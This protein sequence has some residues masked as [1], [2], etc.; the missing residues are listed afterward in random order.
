MYEGLLT[1]I[2]SPSF[3][4]RAK[5]DTIVNML[6]TL[7]GNLVQRCRRLAM[8]KRRSGS[9]SA[10]SLLAASLCVAA[11]ADVVEWQAGIGGSFHDAVNWNPTTVP[12]VTDTAQFSIDEAYGVQ[13]NGTTLVKDLVVTTGRVELN[14]ADHQITILASTPGLRISGSAGNKEP[15]LRIGAG[16]ITTAGGSIGFGSSEHGAVLLDGPG[17]SLTVNWGGQ[18]RIGNYGAGW[19]GV[20]DGATFTTQLNTYV[21]FSPGSFGQLTISGKGSTWAVGGDAYCGYV[22]FGTCLVRSGAVATSKN[23]VVGNGPGAV[24]NL[25][26]RG[27]GSTASSVLVTSIGAA[28]NGAGTLTIAE[29]G[30][31][32]SGIAAI[33]EHTASSGTAVIHGGQSLWSVTDGLYVGLRGHATMHINDGA[34]VTSR[35]GRL[36]HLNGSG[37][38]VSI[39]GNQALWH[40]Q[41]KIEIGT[42][43]GTSG[44]LEVAQHGE[45]IASEVIV[46][47][48]GMLVGDG[49]IHAKITNKG[50][51]R[52][53]SASVVKPNSKTAPLT[54]RELHI[55]PTGRVVIP[56]HISHGELHAVSVRA[57]EHA[58]IAGE[59]IVHLPTLYRPAHGESILLLSATALTGNFDSLSLPTSPFGEYV[60]EQTDAA[61]G[62][63]LRLVF[64]SNTPP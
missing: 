11:S 53:Q 29:G 54:M 63:E 31:V 27:S 47:P 61:D 42:A 43:P 51:I 35:F 49:S 26:V 55:D 25:F 64:Y 12:W 36:G 2:R 59:L 21:G 46:G 9:R 45:I 13:L 62:Q 37:G 7:S 48:T 15:M 20:V 33:G 39:R 40:V 50:T 17:A 32:F 22:G 8:H 57:E 3:S 5:P 18:L 14:G 56:L 28:S 34:T 52:A 10:G 30:T 4:S 6:Q 38:N 44:F 41:Q 23:I 19:L 58:S 60:L 24:G 16:S 1:D